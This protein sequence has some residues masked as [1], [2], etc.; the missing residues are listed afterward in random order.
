MKKAAL[1]LCLVSS[2]VLVGACGSTG[3]EKVASS[4]TKA[5][6]TKEVTKGK[7]A[8]E[9]FDKLYGN[10]KQYKGYEVEMTGKVFTEPEKDN[11]GTYFQVW[12]D[13]EKSEKNTMVAIKDPNLQIKTNDYVKVKGVVK[14]EFNGENSFGGKVTA[15]E[16]VAD[17]VEKVDYI[18]AVA[19]T[20]KEIQVNKE[21]NQNN[22][23][24]TLEKAEL[25]KNQTRIY[26]KVKNGTN[27]NASFYSNA[28]KLIVGSNQ[29][30][31]EYMDPE[32]TGLKEIQSD[33]LP[34]VET[35]GVIVYPAID[36]S[37]G[38]FKVNAEATN[39]NYELD[40]QPYVF[41]VAI[42]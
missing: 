41:D 23:V 28:V 7:L 31:Y 16:I 2:M 12:G 13:P 37:A 25:A 33:L 9:D 1:A 10:P 15:P 39:D 8:A 4:N 32:T 20:L 38:S 14:D 36:Q 18:T 42:N 6:K 40:F 35:E 22:L 26:M 24:I 29:L 3:I 27:V 17:T 21:I 19:P 34:G 5:V 11:S 30:E